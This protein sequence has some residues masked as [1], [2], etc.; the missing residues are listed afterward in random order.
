VVVKTVP[1]LGV[2]LID[3]ENPLPEE[4]ETSNPVGAVITISAVKDAPA[5]VNVELDDAVP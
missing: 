2:K 4:I 1:V 3:D 5:A